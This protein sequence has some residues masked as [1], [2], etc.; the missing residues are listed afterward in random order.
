MILGG[1]PH[2]L[3]SALWWPEGNLDAEPVL[4][5]M[6]VHLFGATSSPSCAVFTLRQ[7]PK[8]YGKFFPPNVAETVLKSFFSLTIC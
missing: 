8:E 5:R 3:V 4:Y 1:G 2:C 6:K 7:T